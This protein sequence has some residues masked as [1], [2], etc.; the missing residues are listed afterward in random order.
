VARRLRLPTQLRGPDAVHRP[1]PLAGPLPRPRPQAHGDSRPGGAGEVRRRSRGKRSASSSATP[2]RPRRRRAGDR[3]EVRLQS[4]RLAV[5]GEVD[6]PAWAGRPSRRGRPVPDLRARP[7]RGQL[8]AQRPLQAAP[9]PRHPL[10]RGT[11]LRPPRLALPRRLPLWPGL[12]DHDRGRRPCVSTPGSANLVE[13]RD[14]RARRRR[15]PRRRRRPQLHRRLLEADPA[16]PPAPGDRPDPLRQLLP[17]A[18]QELEF[19]ANVQLAELPAEIGAV[20]ADFEIAALP[21]ADLA[22]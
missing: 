21:R 7:V 14:P 19:V 4:L 9:R 11:D 3:Q 5:A 10:R 17:P 1:L 18:R 15:L 22:T 6:G 13:Q 20:S 12:G 8:H 2:T 16:D